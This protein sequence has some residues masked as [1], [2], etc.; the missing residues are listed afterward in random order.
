MNIQSQ[1]S[2][3]ELSAVRQRSIRTEMDKLP[4]IEELYCA[5]DRIGNGKAAGET[6]ILP[7]MV[8]VA[9]CHGEFLNKL[10]ELVHNAWR[11]GHVPND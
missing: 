11:K 10:L 5:V 2:L 8:K 3:D 4:S 7:E 6:G 9:C 1:F